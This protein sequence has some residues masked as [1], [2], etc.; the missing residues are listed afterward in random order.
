M[1]MSSEHHERIKAALLAA[2]EK[3]ADEKIAKITGTDEVSAEKRR[4]IR[5]RQLSYTPGA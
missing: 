2:A 1:D 3:Y 5:I 4:V